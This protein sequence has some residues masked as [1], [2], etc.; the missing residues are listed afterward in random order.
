[1][2]RAMRSSEDHARP[3]EVFGRQSLGG[4]RVIYSR[5]APFRLIAG[6]ELGKAQPRAIVRHPLLSAFLA[7]VYC[8]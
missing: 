5:H 4:K 7:N 6:V 1:M 8:D 3:Q 2:Q